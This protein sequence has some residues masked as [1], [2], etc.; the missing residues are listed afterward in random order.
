MPSPAALTAS[1]VIATYNRPDHMVTCLEHLVLQTVAPVET[2]VVDASPDDRTRRVV[3]RFPGVVYLRNTRG[4]GSTATSRAIGVEHVTADV[5]AFIDDDAYARPDWLEQLL[6]RY[7]DE[8]VAGVGGRAINDQPGEEDEGIG[9]IGRFLPDG[10]LTGFF[11]AI[12]PRDVD[13]DHLLGANMS[14]RRSSVLE[15]GGIHDYYPG[16]CLREE[17]DIALRLRIAGKRIVY[18]PEAVVRHVAGPYAKGRRFD[19]RYVY[20][21]YRNHVVLLARTIGAGSPQ[22][23]RYAAVGARAVGSELATAARAVGRFR[24]E[25]ARAAVRGVGGGLA[26][27]GATGAGLA[28]GSLTAL[29]LRRTDGPVPSVRTTIGV[30]GA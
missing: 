21:G 6:E 28:A 8:R 1:V 30:S 19:L 9:Q 16:T 4:P 12:P 5:V 22:M 23:R 15:V 26:R 3:E 20:Y 25:G 10:T 11:A 13:V 2:I 7:A 17:T 29:R 27:A 24:T 14:V 18:T